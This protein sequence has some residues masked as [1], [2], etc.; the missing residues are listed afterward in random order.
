MTNPFKNIQIVLVRPS[1]PGNIGAA[2]RAMKNMG[3]SKLVLVQ[4][5]D[6]LGSDSYTM[7]YGAHDVLEDAKVFKTLPRALARCRYVVGTTARTH[8]GYGKPVPLMSAMPDLLA[9]ANRPLPVA[10]HDPDRR[11]AHLPQPGPGRDG[12]RIRIDES[13]RLE[14]PI[15]IAAA[16][17]NRRHKSTG[18]IL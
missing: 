15:V 18:T 7:A 11:S 12:R 16:T 4:P 13:G 1:R 14:T 8:K 3:L 10:R 2:A 9:R 5:V 6:H 17:G